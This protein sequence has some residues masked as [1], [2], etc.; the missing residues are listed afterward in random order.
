MRVKF[1]LAGKV[2]IKNKMDEQKP[3]IV[4]NSHL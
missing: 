2:H 1:R 4:L 3:E